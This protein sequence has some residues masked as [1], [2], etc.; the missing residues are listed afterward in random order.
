MKPVTLLFA[1]MS[2]MLSC[3][4]QKAFSDLILKAP[5]Q[6]SRDFESK[7]VYREVPVFFKNNREKSVI[8]KNGYASAILQQPIVWPLKLKQYYVKEIRVVFTKYPADKNFWNTNYYDLLSARLQAVFMIDPTLNDERINYRLLLQTGCAS[9]EEAKKMLHGIEIVYEI[10]QRPKDEDDKTEEIVTDTLPTIDSDSLAKLRDLEKAYKFYRKTKSKDTLVLGGL[11]R[12]GQTDSLL[13]VIDCTGSMSPYYSQVSLW[14]AQNFQPD[15]YYVM[16]ND[17]GSRLLPLGKTGGYEEGRVRSVAELIK[18]FK[19]ASGIRGSNKEVAENDIEGLLVGI[20][21]FPNNKGVILVAD[22]AACVRDYKLLGKVNQP[23]HVI[24][25][26]EGGILNPLFLNIAWYT[27]GSVFWENE[28]IHNWNELCN[29]EIFQLG[30]YWYKFNRSQQHFEALDVNG[31]HYAFCE[32]YSFK[33]RKK[34][35]N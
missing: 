7:F 12:F 23:V 35:K 14:A 17:G 26:G 31:N 21:A 2:C 27:G 16:F 19:K 22:N 10:G 8:L 15:H 28:Y 20:Q 13:I 34:L 18:L 9:E 5:Q 29:G 4:G 33:L 11:N 24:A 3:V 6:Y 32:G 30:S 25:C 1:L